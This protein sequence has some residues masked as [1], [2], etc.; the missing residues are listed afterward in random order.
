[1]LVA[2]VPGSA[3]G[4]LDLSLS[5]LALAALAGLCGAVLSRLLMMESAKYLPAATTTLIGLSS[6][7]IGLVAD[8]LLLDGLPGTRAWIGGAIVAVGLLLAIGPGSTASTGEA[9]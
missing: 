3:A 2:L 8:G 4:A 1:M 5:L 9:G 7:V 6:P